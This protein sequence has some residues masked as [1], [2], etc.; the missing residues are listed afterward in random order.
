M[1]WRQGLWEVNGSLGQENCEWGYCPDKRDLRELSVHSA[2]WRSEKGD[3]H[4]GKQVLAR[5]TEV[6]ARGSRPPQP[7]AVSGDLLVFISQKISGTQWQQ[8]RWTDRAGLYCLS[9]CWRQWWGSGQLGLSPPQGNSSLA[10]P[11]QHCEKDTH[12]VTLLLHLHFLL[13]PTTHLTIFFAADIPTSILQWHEWVQGPQRWHEPMSQRCL[14]ERQT[15]AVTWENAMLHRTQANMDKEI[16][17]TQH[18]QIERSKERRVRTL[19]KDAHKHSRWYCP[20]RNRKCDWTNKDGIEWK[21]VWWEIVVVM[22]IKPYGL[23]FL[24]LRYRIKIISVQLE[25]LSQNWY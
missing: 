10:P 15:C 14:A 23:H 24:V 22:I 2:I 12:S 17:R 16:G 5:D 4:E 18:L 1:F 3:V 20:H 8:P 7:R 6:V 9:L 25:L 11:P 13:K 21:V 19:S